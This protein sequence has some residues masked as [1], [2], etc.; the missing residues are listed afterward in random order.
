M[1]AFNL[2]KRPGAGRVIRLTLASIVVLVT[3]LLVSCSSQNGGGSLINHTAPD[4][5]L[6]DLSGQDFT[7]SDLRGKTVLIN[8]W[9]TTCPPCVQEMPNFQAL[10]RDWS[11]RPDF[12]FLSINL[13]ES[14]GTIQNFM[15]A[16][17]YTFPVLQDSAY[18]VAEKYLIQYTPTSLLVDK[19]GLI[20]MDLIGPFP[21]ESSLQ[22]WILPYLPLSQSH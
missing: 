3:L 18:A 14:A 2:G 10:Y 5:R 12:V 20:K 9:D 21:S 17:G 22:K 8:F 11:S 7:L 15:S 1:V 4:F 13:G 16:N 6:R 19:T